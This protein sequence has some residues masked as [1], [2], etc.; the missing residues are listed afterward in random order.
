MSKINTKAYKKMLKDY[1]DAGFKFVKFGEF[2]PKG[3]KQI[4]LRHDVDF[5]VALAMQM[6]EIEEEM[7]IR[8]SYFFLTH[9]AAY[10]ITGVP[11]QAFHRLGH[12]TGLHMDYSE[13]LVTED[14]ELQQYYSIHRPEKKHLNTDLALST[15]CK[16]FFKK[17]EYFSDSKCKMPNT[18]K[19]NGQLLIHPLWWILEGDTMEEKLEE[20]KRHKANQFENYIKSNITL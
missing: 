16:K 6:A 17:I 12:Y 5:D 7:N 15:Y 18:I 11:T 4:L 9:G 2:D 3:K 19:N 14:I 10:N 13:P 20:L 1:Q 8:S